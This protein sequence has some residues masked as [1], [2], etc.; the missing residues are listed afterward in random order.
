MIERMINEINTALDNNLYFSAL[1]L[2]LVLPDSCAKAEY[3][4]EPKNNVR[5]KNWYKK[6]V[7]DSIIFNDEG[8]PNVDENV[9]YNLRCCFLHEGNPNIKSG[10]GIDQFELI[11][12]EKDPSPDI[13]EADDHTTIFNCKYWDMCGT[14][15]ATGERFYR[16]NVR[17]YCE[18][19]CEC[20]S[21]YYNENKAKFSFNYTILDW[22]DI[23]P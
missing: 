14:D 5:Y 20:V 13:V 15:S 3:P 17:S 10:Y 9:A 11:F 8:L 23:K 16:I 18:R 1:A 21:G 2:T 22:E 12:Q 19:I 7:G 4:T 6:F